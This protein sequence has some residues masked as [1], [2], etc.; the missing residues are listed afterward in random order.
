MRTEDIEDADDQGGDS[1][2]DALMAQI[3]T[4]YPQG[5]TL[6][7]IACT[8]ESQDVW[9]DDDDLADLL[10]GLIDGMADSVDQAARERGCRSRAGKVVH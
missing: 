1:E 2:L 4:L 8:G 5:T 7:L 10:I 6:T 9:S 3:A